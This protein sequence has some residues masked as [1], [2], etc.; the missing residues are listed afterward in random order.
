MTNAV[1]REVCVRALSAVRPRV[2]HAW[3]ARIAACGGGW[4]FALDACFTSDQGSGPIRL[5][6]GKQ[7]IMRYVLMI[8]APRGRLRSHT[9]ESSQEKSFVDSE[10]CYMPSN[11]HAHARTTGKTS[12]GPRTLGASG[13]ISIYRDDGRAAGGTS[14]CVSCSERVSLGFESYGRCDEGRSYR[15]GSR[16]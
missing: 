2:A 16:E 5:S 9:S 8:K 14:Y 1:S 10:A 7:G 13:T 4:R 12:D 6:I 3:V 11:G 15:S